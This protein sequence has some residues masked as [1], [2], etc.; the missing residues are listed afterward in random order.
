M[1]VNHYH[2]GIIPVAI[3]I[4]IISPASQYAVEWRRIGAW[5]HE[6]WDTHS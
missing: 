3:F 5:P 2:A 1:L 6:H 4:V